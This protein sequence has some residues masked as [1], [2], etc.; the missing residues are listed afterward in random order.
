MR[1]MPCTRYWVYIMN[2]HVK[3]VDAEVTKVLQLFI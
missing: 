2:N 3:G 1:I